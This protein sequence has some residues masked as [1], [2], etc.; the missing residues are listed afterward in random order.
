MEDL[1]L[2]FRKE[3]LKDLKGLIKDYETQTKRIQKDIETE[4]T[5]KNDK[6]YVNL[7]A[8]LTNLNA[9]L[10]NLKNQKFSMEREIERELENRAAQQEIEE[11]PAIEKEVKE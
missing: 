2:K 1:E 9:T 6:R 3:M 8:V 4:R 10:S 11:V 7:V 5:F